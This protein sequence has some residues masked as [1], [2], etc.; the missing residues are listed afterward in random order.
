M[1]EC[2]FNVASFIGS[3]SGN[4][5]PNVMK[6]KLSD[7][8]KVSCNFPLNILTEAEHTRLLD[9]VRDSDIDNDK[10]RSSK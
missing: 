6:V 8:F 5:R 10:V 2:V 3:N 1:H 4:P 7:I 9:K